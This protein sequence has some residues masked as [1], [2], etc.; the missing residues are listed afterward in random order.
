MFVK[1]GVG[2]Q[3]VLLG[4]LG[5]SFSLLGNHSLGRET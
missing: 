5:T 3:T 2:V 4:I 1:L